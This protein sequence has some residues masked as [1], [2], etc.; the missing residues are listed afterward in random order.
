MGSSLKS[1]F[2]GRIETTFY[3]TWVL[4]WLRGPRGGTKLLGGF[5]LAPFGFPISFLT[6]KG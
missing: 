4:E 1:L 6:P 2:N 3:E 5:T